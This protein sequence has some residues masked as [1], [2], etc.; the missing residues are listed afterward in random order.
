MKGDNSNLLA[1]VFVCLVTVLIIK[2]VE[3]FS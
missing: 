1:I 3:Y 2:M